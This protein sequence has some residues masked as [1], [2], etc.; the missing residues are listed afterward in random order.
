MKQLLTTRHLAGRHHM[1]VNANRVQVG[2]IVIR[3]FT[4][5]FTVPVP[6]SSTRILIL[7][8]NLARRHVI[9][10]LLP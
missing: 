10:I 1:H 7:L 3:M 9:I 8:N 6:V 2:T 4:V 5:A